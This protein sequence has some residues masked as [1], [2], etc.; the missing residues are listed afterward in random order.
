MREFRGIFPDSPF[1]LWRPRGVD[2]RRARHLNVGA[3]LLLAARAKGA[4]RHR[5]IVPF[6][7]KDGRPPPRRLMP[8]S[9]T[10]S[11]PGAGPVAGDQANRAA[12]ASETSHSLRASTGSSAAGRGG[13]RLQSAKYAPETDATA[14]FTAT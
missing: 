11:E 6:T 9:E 12:I 14:G 4:R 13:L 3:K 10:C 2:V 5:L 7:C 8:P 1:G